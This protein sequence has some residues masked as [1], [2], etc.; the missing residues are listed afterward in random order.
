MKHIKSINEL[1]SAIP[2]NKSKITDK[3]TDQQILR[4]G[5]LAELDAINLYEQLA[6]NATN[7]KVKD[8]LLDISREEKTHVGEFETLLL[9]LDKEQEQETKK[10]KKEVEKLD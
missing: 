7:K 5:I 2:V 8:L 10:G 4:T 3:N 9:E 1:L 6:A